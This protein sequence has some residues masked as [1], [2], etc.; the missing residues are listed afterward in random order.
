M[1]IFLTRTFDDWLND[2]KDLAGQL[3]I[4]RRIQRMQLGN[5][6]TVRSV[7]AGVMEMKIDFGPG[8]RVYYVQRGR[9]IVVLLCGGNKSTQ[10]KD[11]DKAK[12]LANQADLEDQWRSI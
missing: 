11:I 7:G 4:G 1:K 10:Q 3:A 2:L 9:S 5:P 8:Y 6:G 12:K